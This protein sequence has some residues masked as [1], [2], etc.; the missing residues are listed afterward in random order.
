MNAATKTCH[1]A[2]TEINGKEGPAKF[3]VWKQYYNLPKNS[4]QTMDISGS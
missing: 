4:F 3:G 1:T 2:E